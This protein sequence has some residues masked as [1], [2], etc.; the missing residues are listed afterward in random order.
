MGSIEVLK[1]RGRDPHLSK[2]VWFSPI[3]VSYKSM[4]FCEIVG[5]VSKSSISNTRSYNLLKLF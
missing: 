4:E 1:L 5:M 3:V 2:R